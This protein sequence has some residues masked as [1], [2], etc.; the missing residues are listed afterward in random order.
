MKIYLTTSRSFLGHDNDVISWPIL[1]SHGE[2]AFNLFPLSGWVEVIRN[3]LTCFYLYAFK[4]VS[5]FCLFISR[6][7]QIA[8]RRHLESPLTA[9][10][11]I[12]SK[13]IFMMSM[14][15][16]IPQKHSKA[17]NWH[18]TAQLNLDKIFLIISSS[19]RCA[20]SIDTCARK[21]SNKANVMNK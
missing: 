12:N 15:W 13:S 18:R 17:F 1:F 11:L 3:L 20:I 2:R 10:I 8:L 9:K 14:K 6:W 16:G 21:I 19:L 4:L 5:C 7:P